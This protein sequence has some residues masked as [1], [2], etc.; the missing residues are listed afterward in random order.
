MTAKLQRNAENAMIFL[1]GLYRKYGYLLSLYDECVQRAESAAAATAAFVREVIPTKDVRRAYFYT[2]GLGVYEA[3]VNGKSVKGGFLKPGWQE[4]RQK[5]FY[6]NEDGS[7]SIG[8]TEIDGKKYL[9]GSDGYMKT[10]LQTVDGVRRYFDKSSGEMVI[11]KVVD[12]VSVDENGVA[13]ATF[14]VITTDNIDDYLAYI[15]KT[16]GS[17][18]KSLYKWVQKTVPSYVYY[19]EANV[20]K[21]RSE[22]RIDEL[23]RLLAVE[24]INKGKGACWHY[25]ALMR[26]L[27]EKA[28]YEAYTV[29]GGGHSANEHNWNVV[30]QD[31]VFYHIDVMRMA[32]AIYMIPDSQLSNYKYNYQPGHGPH[33]DWGT[34]YTDV[35]YYGYTL[36][37]RE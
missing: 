24:A 30:Y 6:T 9:F 36:P 37:T 16:Q 29:M 27:L 2:T 25:A 22:G 4:W 17:D 32:V 3:F 23:E 21:Y 8:L 19:S 34:S 11:N 35:Y 5:K 15:I 10:G 12:G 18:I 14:E 26:L 13:T 31:G 1:R 33:A 28:G 7:V 20:K